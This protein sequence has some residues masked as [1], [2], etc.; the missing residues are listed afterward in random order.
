MWRSADPKAIRALAHP[1]RLDLLDLLV[2]LGPDD[3]RS[4]RAGSSRY[5]RRAAP[6]TCASSPST[7]SS[8]TP[9]QA[10][11]GANDNGGCPT[12]GSACRVVTSSR[13]SSQQVI[14]ERAMNEILDYGARADSDNP[15]GHGFRGPIARCALSCRPTRPPRSGRSGR[16][17]L[18]RTLPGPS[19]AAFGSSQ[20]S[21][22]SGTSWPGRR[23]LV[24]TRPTPSRRTT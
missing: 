7:G 15:D 8:R 6:F 23:C 18:R 2:A 20:A 16:S 5:R 19:G 21:A 1:L 11:T 13:G 12:P 3:S 17:C 24:S 14:V 9:A 22:M 10:A 4:V